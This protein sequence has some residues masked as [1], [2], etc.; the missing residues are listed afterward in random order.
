MTAGSWQISWLLP[1]TSVFWKFPWI[2]IGWGGPL[3]PSLDGG[4]PMPL[5]YGKPWKWLF[6]VY[7]LHYCLNIHLVPWL[8]SKDGS[9][10]FIWRLVLVVY[11]GSDNNRMVCTISFPFPY[12]ILFSAPSIKKKLWP[13]F[14]DG[15][16]L[17]LRLQ[18]LRGGNILFTTKFPSIPGTRF[19]YLRRMKGWVKPEYLITVKL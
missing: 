13:L 7:H 14:M 4:P 19:I 12:F 5:H 10:M 11:Q 3:C 9:L 15:V 16:Q 1:S 6:E 17:H 8:S 18:E 2:N